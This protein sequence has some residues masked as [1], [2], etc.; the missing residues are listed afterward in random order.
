M[1]Q[2][3]SSMTASQATEK[4]T[5]EQKINTLATL[6]IA[7]NESV[8]LELLEAATVCARPILTSQKRKYPR[9]GNEFENRVFETLDGLLKQQNIDTGRFVDIFRAAFRRD[10]QD[11]AKKEWRHNKRNRHFT[12]YINTDEDPYRRFWATLEAPDRNCHVDGR[13]PELKRILI[14]TLSKLPPR[15]AVIFM[16]W[17]QHYPHTDIATAVGEETS[18]T[19]GVIHRT[20]IKLRKAFCERLGEPDSAT[21]IGAILSDEEIAALASIVFSRTS[22]AG[23][24]YGNHRGR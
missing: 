14:E 21:D 7:G 17:L 12:D 20:K 23:A 24:P 18:A 6:Y 1:I 2:R 9:I 13:A 22:D 8:F 4:A 16:L 11:V 10:L 19:E 3:Y 15:D 5:L